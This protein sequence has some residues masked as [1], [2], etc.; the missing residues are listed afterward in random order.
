MRSVPDTAAAALLLLLLLLFS[1][2]YAK[3]PMSV[4]GVA[5]PACPMI[6]VIVVMIGT[7]LNETDE[8]ELLT[9]FKITEK[10]TDEPMEMRLSVKQLTLVDDNQMLLR[11]VTASLVVEDDDDDDADVTV[12]VIVSVFVFPFP[13]PLPDNIIL[14]D[15][16]AG[17]DVGVTVVIIG[18]MIVITRNED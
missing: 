18:R 3:L 1:L 12:Y 15:C 8:D 6:G 7:A 13:N 2:L 14:F 4:I 11:Q 9:P 5:I 17:I 10:R 16:K